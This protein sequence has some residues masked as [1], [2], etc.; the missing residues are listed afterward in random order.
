MTNRNQKVVSF[1]DRAYKTADAAIGESLTIKRDKRH[2]VT[3]TIV[4]AEPHRWTQRGRREHVVFRI[5]MECGT[6]KVR[7]TF[8][9]TKLPGH[10]WS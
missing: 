9:V 6:A 2:R 3:G 7:K 5:I 10:H 4:N 1:P 8:Y